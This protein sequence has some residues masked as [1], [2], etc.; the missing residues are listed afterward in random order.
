[1][2]YLITNWSPPVNWC[3]IIG[4]NY[5]R[6]NDTQHEQQDSDDT[7]DLGNVDRDIPLQ[8]RHNPLPRSAFSSV[9]KYLYYRQFPVFQVTHEELSLNV[10]V[11][12]DWFIQQRR[13][14]TCGLH[15]SGHLVF[16]AHHVHAPSTDWKEDSAVDDVI[17]LP[18]MT[19][20]RRHAMVWRETKFTRVMSVR[21]EV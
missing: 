18:W 4:V 3:P 9:V 11:K 14:L 13:S 5:R 16:F 12:F 8:I 10:V 6:C 20:L 21:W 7:T 17:L 1:M 15:V 19:L 2:G